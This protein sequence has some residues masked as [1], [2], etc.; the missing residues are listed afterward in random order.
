MRFNKYNPLYLVSLILLVVVSGCSKDTSKPNIEVI[1]DM[2]ESPAIK[3]QEYIEE[4]V[5]H[6]GMLLPPENTVPVGFKPY[7]YNYDPDGAEK[8][9][10]NP[11]SGDLSSGVLLVGQK[12]YET[13]CAL[14]HGY[15][16]EGLEA[17]SIGKVMALK[18][19]PL[20]SDKVK[21]WPDARIYHVI[22]DGQGIMPSYATHV[23]Q[24]VRW[25][26]VNYIRHLQNK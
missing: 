12:Q 1:Q 21:T 4:A 26:L 25:Q 5:D 6:R 3:T 15:K 18:P 10:K 9:L 16:G 20:I 23:P 17:T 14:C 11:F 8:N 19:P 7:R 24:S 22:S 13:Q 2:M